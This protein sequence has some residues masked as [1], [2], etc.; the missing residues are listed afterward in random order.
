MYIPVGFIYVTTRLQ[1]TF[2][3]I[4]NGLISFPN[5][6]WNYI[7]EGYFLFFLTQ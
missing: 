4:D 5:V 3:K 2:L 7:R 1:G 6:A